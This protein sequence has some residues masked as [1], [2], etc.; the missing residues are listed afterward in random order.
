[1]FTPAGLEGVQ[2]ATTSCFETNEKYKTVDGSTLFT[3]DP[4]IVEPF[5]T[6][7]TENSPAFRKSDVP[8]LIYHGEADQLI[9]VSLSKIV[10]DKYCK[11]GTVI[12]R[13]TY[14]GA[15]HTGVIPLAM[16]NI[17]Q[18]LADRLSGKPAPNQCS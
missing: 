12:S 1:L 9:P 6:L 14:P 7:L 16:T 2:M 18:Y 8:I 10:F 11:L 3:A 5:A 15:S 13:Q 17:Q 4:G